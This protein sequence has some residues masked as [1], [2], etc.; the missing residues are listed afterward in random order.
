M[1]ELYLLI[2]QYHSRVCGGACAPTKVCSVL[3]CSSARRGGQHPAAHPR[4]RGAGVPVAP[5]NVGGV[6][7][8]FA[9]RPPPR[10]S[11]CRYRGAWRVTAWRR[12][13]GGAK[14]R[15]ASRRPRPKKLSRKEKR[16]RQ[17]R[18]VGAFIYP[19]SVSFF[20][21]CDV[22]LGAP[23]W[24]GVRGCRFWERGYSA[25]HQPEMRCGDNLR[26][27]PAAGRP[28][29]AHKQNDRG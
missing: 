25:A 11:E 4:G 28:L 26:G 3:L 19:C 23:Y 24:V 20:L 18:T 13:L 2:F 1:F 14:G 5:P 9:T 16:H 17:G 10:G 22:F 6:S 29:R 15:H 7:R 21:C 8:F 27:A 12:A